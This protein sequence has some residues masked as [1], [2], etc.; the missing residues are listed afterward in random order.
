MKKG[1]DSSMNKPLGMDEVSS[2]HIKV[3]LVAAHPHLPLWSVILVLRRQ[4]GIL[5]ASCSVRPVGPVSAGLRRNSTSVNK[6]L[7]PIIWGLEGQEKDTGHFLAG[8]GSA[9]K[10]LKNRTCDKK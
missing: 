1:L 3:R 10:T 9:W 2:T 8:A 7:H 4:S 5:K 6:V